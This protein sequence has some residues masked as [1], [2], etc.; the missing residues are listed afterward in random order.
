MKRF[1][2]ALILLCGLLQSSQGSASGSSNVYLTVSRFNFSV[3]LKRVVELKNEKLFDLF[4]SNKQ[5]KAYV[6]EINPYLY[7]Q[8]HFYNCWGTDAVVNFEGIGVISFSYYP[9]VKATLGF[10]RNNELILLQPQEGT[11]YPKDALCGD[12]ISCADVATIPPPL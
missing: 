7:Q 11:G 1:F 2:L 6:V 8:I 9:E 5:S 4:E 3:T 10:T 12:E